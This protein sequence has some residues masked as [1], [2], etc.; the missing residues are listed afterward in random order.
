MRKYDASRWGEDPLES[1][2][3]A[4]SHISYISHLAW[5]ISEYKY[6]ICLLPMWLWLAKRLFWL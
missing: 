3:G 4:D 6:P 1:L 5:M 2:D